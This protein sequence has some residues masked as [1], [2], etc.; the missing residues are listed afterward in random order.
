MARPNIVFVIS[1]DTDFSMLGFGGGTV[2]TPNLDRLAREGMQADQFYTCATLCA[3][4]RYSYLT[5]HYAGRCPAPRS[6][7]A[8]PPGEPRFVGQNAELRPDLERSVAHV[9][10]GAGYRTGF[11]GKWHVGATP[12]ELGIDWFNKDDDPADRAVAS[13]L[14]QHQEVV[15][16]EIRRC[17]FDFAASVSWSNADSRPVHALRHH[18]LEWI[19][20]GAHD[21]LDDA[22]GRGEPFFLMVATSTMHGPSHVESLKSDPRITAAGYETGHVDALPPR[23]TVFRRIEDAGID[24]NHRTAGALWTDDLVGSLMKR[25]DD[26]G[27]A[28]N[29]VFI[30]A[31]DH[32]AFDGKATVYQGGIRL[33]FVVRWPGTVAE[34]SASNEL[35][36]NV[37]LAPTLMEIAQATPPR[38]MVLDGESLVPAWK[39]GAVQRED[40]YAEFGYWRGI[41]DGRWKYMTLRFP[42]RFLEEIRA[43]EVPEDPGDNVLFAKRLRPHVALNAKRYP[44]LWEPEQF[45]DL[46]SDPEE[47]RNLVGVPEKESSGGVGGPA[48][49]RLAQLRERLRG[50]VESLD[51]PYAIDTIDELMYSAKYRRLGAQVA[52]Y[53]MNRYAWYRNGWY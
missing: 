16:S 49:A 22:S 25:I 15:R 47:Q 53:D 29:T 27:E 6:A 38:D 44:H 52:E 51:R 33:P 35:M 20:K 30:Y 42:D 7:E 1:D 50:Y 48:A 45:Y 43:A 23:D 40:V 28:E 12:R 5:G 19:A 4:S 13:R 24:V 17:G 37:D 39:G 8:D 11:V 18:N 41:T 36:Q 31:T 14:Q 21:F 9:L 46:E 3:P 34:G 26:A 32:G 2:L 10:Q